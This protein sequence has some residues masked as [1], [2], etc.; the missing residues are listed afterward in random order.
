MRLQQRVPYHLAMEWALTGELIPAARAYDVSLVNRLTAPGLALDAA[1][2]L[3]RTVAAN[4]PLAV[5]ATKRI[6][7]ESPEWSRAEMF[8]RQ[9]EISEPVRASEDAKEGAT[10]FKEKRAPRW[11]G[12]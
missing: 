5:A 1:L 9:R 12:V 10:A 7:V 11:R 8:V 6:V 4:G 3:A 2:E